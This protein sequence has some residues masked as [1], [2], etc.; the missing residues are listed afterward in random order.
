MWI[1]DISLLCENELTSVYIAY[2]KPPFIGSPTTGQ[3]V[4]MRRVR[5]VNIAVEVKKKQPASVC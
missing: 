5:D 3:K 2:V 4:Y 1:K